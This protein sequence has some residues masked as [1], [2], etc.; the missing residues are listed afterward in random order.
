MLDY[1]TWTPENPLCGGC[2]KRF[3]E[4]QLTYLPSWQFHACPACAIECVRVDAEEQAAEEPQFQLTS[5]TEMPRL[6]PIR[7]KVYQPTRK[8]IA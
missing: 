6:E 3:P 2:G 8:E 4:E 5:P 7:V 1:T